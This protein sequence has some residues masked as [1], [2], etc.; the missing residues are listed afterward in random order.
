MFVTT[1]GVNFLPLSLGL[2][3]WAGTGVA[4]VDGLLFY[5]YLLWELN[6][7]IEKAVASYLAGTHPHVRSV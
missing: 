4:V 2:P 1:I 3:E 7:P 5:I 6:G